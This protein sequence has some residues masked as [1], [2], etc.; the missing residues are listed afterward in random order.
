M[1]DVRRSVG[2]WKADGLE[3]AFVNVRDSGFEGRVGAVVNLPL[4]ES[5]AARGEQVVALKQEVLESS[6]LAWSKLRTD[7]VFDVE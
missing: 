7:F 6:R 4:E 1:G 2:W 5:S 3:E